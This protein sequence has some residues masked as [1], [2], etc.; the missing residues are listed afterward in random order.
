MFNLQ[1]IEDVSAGGANKRVC[2]PKNIFSPAV[3]STKHP[4]TLNHLNNII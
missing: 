3:T 1:I 4:S 2:P